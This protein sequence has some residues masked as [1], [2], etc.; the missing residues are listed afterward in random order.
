MA[1]ADPK[2]PT[3][4]TA[5]VK[6]TDFA[7]FL[8]P[9]RA[10]YLFEQARKSSS[11]M[12][13]ARQ[14]PMGANGVEI[15]FSTYKATAKWV[16]EAGQKPTTESGISLKTLK[17]SK[18]A[19]ICVVS[20]EVVRANPGNYMEVLRADIAE[21]FAVA[22]DNAILHGTDSPFGAGNNI[23]ATTKSVALG[24]AAATAGSVYGDVVAGL[25]ALVSDGKRLTGFAFDKTVEPLFLG[26]L[27]TAGRPLFIE[28][29]SA[30]TTAPQMQGGRLIGRPAFLGD[31]IKNTPAGAGAKA[32]LGYGGDWDQVVWG[33][34]GGVQYKVSTEATVTIGGTLTSLF[35]HNLVAI[36]AEAEYGA[37]V[38][39]PQ[40]F[41]K[42][43]AK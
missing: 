42:Y 36:L 26:S 37:L 8:R 28:T 30:E 38:N 7:G 9:D 35:E 34:V 21:A 31:N 17:P 11:V 4:Q 41:V 22:F 25:S 13:L 43:T 24:T 5:P 23:D 40:A 27:D 6:T 12:Q 19:A 18:L 29:P 39:D 32:T 33:V 16:A 2:N 3:P 14:I 15:P 1:V 20:A 10:G